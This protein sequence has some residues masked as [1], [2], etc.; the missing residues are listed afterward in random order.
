MLQETEVID[1]EWN[2]GKTNELH[3]VV[4]VHP[5]TMDGKQ[6]SRASAHNYGFLLES[7][8]SIGCKVILSLASDIIPFIYKITD[9]TPY[10]EQR[11]NLPSYDTYQDGCHLYKV[12]SEKEITE[13]KFIQ[14]AG[15]LNIRRII[16]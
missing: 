4:I 5:V 13:M 8:L 11:L 16:L 10:N 12:L 3:P 9:T 1:I 15:A 6:V 14:S 2:T 7:K